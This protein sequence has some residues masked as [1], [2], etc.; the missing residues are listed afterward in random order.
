MLVGKKNA[1]FEKAIMEGDVQV[2]NNVAAAR[3]TPV[4]N[5]R[6]PPMVTP[7]PLKMEP[8]DST[9]VTHEEMLDENNCHEITNQ[10]QKMHYA[11][12]AVLIGSDDM[13]G[14][15]VAVCSDT[16]QKSGRPQT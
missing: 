11:N 16:S 5:F 12:D 15:M 1:F 6:I 4:A 3:C 9:P 2:D 7:P 14:S 13:S 8:V 10:N